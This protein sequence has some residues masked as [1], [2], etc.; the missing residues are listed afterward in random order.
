MVAELVH[1][2]LLPE[3]KKQ[4]LRDKGIVAC[5][6]VTTIPSSSSLPTSQTSTKETFAGSS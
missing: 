3:V 6:L 2:F 4:T 5:V 1:T